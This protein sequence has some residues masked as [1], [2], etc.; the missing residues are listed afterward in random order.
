MDHP[1][2]GQQRTDGGSD[3]TAQRFIDDGEDGDTAPQHAGEGGT[4]A[5]VHQPFVVNPFAVQHVSADFCRVGARRPHHAVHHGQRPVGD[6][7]EQTDKDNGHLHFGRFPHH[8]VGG[9]H[10]DKDQNRHDGGH[11]DDGEHKGPQPEQRHD[12]HGH[13]GGQRIT[14]ARPHRFPARVADVDRHRER[15]THQAAQHGGQTVGQH[16]LAGRVLISRCVGALD[17]FQVKDVVRQPQ[18][19]RRR[20]I[21]QRVRQPLHKAVDMH[22]RRVKAEGGH[23]GFDRLRA[24]QAGDPRQCRTGDQQ[25]QTGGDAGEDRLFAKPV[26]EDQQQHDERHGRRFERLQHRVHRQQQQT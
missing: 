25:K 16:H 4:V 19:N 21:R 11:R 10:P 24:L 13:T 2:Q 3:G 7:R 6:P 20:Q 8:L 5:E 22:F 17:V 14:D 15:V 1:E 12:E 26:D 9:D 18:R 23:R